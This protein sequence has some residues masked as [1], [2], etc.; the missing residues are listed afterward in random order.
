M[1]KIRKESIYL[2]YVNHKRIHKNLEMVIEHSTEENP[3]AICK[4]KSDSLQNGMAVKCHFK[5]SKVPSSAM[6]CMGSK[7]CKGALNEFSRP[8]VLP[9]YGSTDD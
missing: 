8:S 6:L 4:T 5:N 1:D 7:V 3:V 9:E 2:Y